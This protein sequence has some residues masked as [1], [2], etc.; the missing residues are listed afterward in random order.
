AS[1]FGTDEQDQL[2]SD[3]ASTL[4]SDPAVVGYYVQDEPAISVLPETFHQYSLI[5]ANDPSGF[6]LTVLNGPLDPPFWKDTV[7]VLGVDPY[8]ITQASGNDLATVADWT[9]AAYQAGHGSRPVWTVIEF[10]QATLE[11]AWPTQQ[12]LHDMSW[13]AIV[14]GATGLFYWEYG[15]PGLEE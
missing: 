11:S 14:E 15:L 12:Q 1:E 9:R 3:F 13:M 4:S 2:I 7:D 6:N 10:F 8:P 5:K